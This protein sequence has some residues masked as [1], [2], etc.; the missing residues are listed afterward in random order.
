MT[1]GFLVTV[2]RQAAVEDWGAV[3]LAEKRRGREAAQ[4]AGM[5]EERGSR[6]KP[7]GVVWCN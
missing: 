1:N 2:H 4:G 6:E 5:A 7:R 3:E